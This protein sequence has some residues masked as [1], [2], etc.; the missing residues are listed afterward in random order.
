MGD[1]TT[2]RGPGTAP[3]TSESLALRSPRLRLLKVL[4]ISFSPSNVQ[5]GEL[6]SIDIGRSQGEE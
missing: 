2:W 1:P 4:G 5:S 3:V 6:D